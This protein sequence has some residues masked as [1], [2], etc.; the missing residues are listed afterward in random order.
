[1]SDTSALK[2][3]L[4]HPIVCAKCSEEVLQGRS[5][6]LSMRE[7]AQVDV[8]F[9]GIG[10]QVWCRRHN[11]NIVHVDFQGNRLPADFRCLEIPKKQ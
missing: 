3:N 4:T 9:T 5:G 2:Y 6:G 10:I 11:C 8:G 7:Y 1:M